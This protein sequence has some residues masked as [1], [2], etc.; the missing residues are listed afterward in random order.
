MSDTHHR[1]LWTELRA[2][3]RGDGRLEIPSLVT[4]VDTGY[5]KVRYALGENGER[6]LLI[7]VSTSCPGRSF[8]ETGSLKVRL[9]RLTLA[10]NNQQFIDL[11]CTDSTLDQ[12]FGELV[13]EIL[14]RI[15]SGREPFAAVGSTL[16]DFRALLFP[17]RTSEINLEA[18]VGLLG[19]LHV[20]DLL[21]R[22][23]IKAVDCW[24][25]PLELRHDFRTESHAVE[26]KATRR[27]DSSETTIHGIDQLAPPPGGKLLLVKV[28][29]EPAPDGAIRLANLYQALLEVGVS[30]EALRER[31]LTAGCEDPLAPAWNSRSFTLESISAWEVSEGFPRLT[32]DEIEAGSLPPGV[33]SVQYVIDLAI[34]SRYR[35]DEKQFTSWL[36][37][38]MICQE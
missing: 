32:S 23:S 24:V 5:G 13:D 28:V 2:S 1:E 25:G 10:G 31:L 36:D 37:E 18:L 22:R 34:A 6:R 17:S 35:L 38:M 9:S 16:E 4:G 26:V 30:R 20:L 14:A 27:S 15:S 11:I 21:T 8:G 12:V 19:E 33:S 3:G 7:P 29:L